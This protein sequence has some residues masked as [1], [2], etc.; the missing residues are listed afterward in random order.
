MIMF[1]SFIMYTY[2]IKFIY[3]YIDHVIYIYI[4]FLISC[5]HT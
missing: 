1:I 4:Y 2:M 3:T 5:I